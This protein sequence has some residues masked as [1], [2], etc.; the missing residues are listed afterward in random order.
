MKIKTPP[1]VN[2]KQD[3]LDKFLSQSG[4]LDC[5][6]IQ[7]INRAAS[8]KMIIDPDIP[9]YISVITCARARVTLGKFKRDFYSF[10]YDSAKEWVA[11]VY[12]FAA[13][14]FGRSVTVHTVLSRGGKPLAHRIYLD[15]SAK[16][17]FTELCTANLISVFLNRKNAVLAEFDM[18][19]Q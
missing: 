15:G 16:P 14:L 19:R 5:E 7:V 6:R 4:T 13:G 18:R 3:F 1:G 10:D 9:F 2:T 8:I 11:A 17:Y 12:N